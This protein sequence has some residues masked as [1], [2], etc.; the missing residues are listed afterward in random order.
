MNLPSSF[1]SVAIER[2][3]VAYKQLSPEERAKVVVLAAKG[4]FCSDLFENWSRQSGV[5]GE[6]L[7]RCVAGAGSLDGVRERLETTLLQEGNEALLIE[8][9]NRFLAENPGAFDGL[10]QHASNAKQSTAGAE[11]QSPGALP[12]DV[13]PP[14]TAAVPVEKNEVAV[15]RDK[16][17][18]L[19]QLDE[20]EALM[21]SVDSDIRRLRD[22]SGPIDLGALE[23]KLHRASRISL[24][25]H[26]Y[27][28]ELGNWQ[29]A[30]ALRE[31]IEAIPDAH[32]VWAG[33]LADFLGRVP[34]N[35]PLRRKRGELES[36]RD[37][38]ISDLRNFA[39]LGGVEEEVPGPSSVVRDWWD[40]AIGLS[41]D[42]FPGLEDWCGT[43]SLD[44]LADFLMEQWTLS[45]LAA[46]VAVRG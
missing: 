43:N 30:G 19:G 42:D 8:A 25:L 17:A 26:Q 28:A 9:V 37:A 2:L 18:A 46:I 16:G 44:H 24:G 21:E 5:D 14:Q 11:P 22:V 10:R 7:L 31:A 3:R 33:Q 36:L 4:R 20:L 1:D 6:E 29:S 27:G 35:H 45:R 15:P 12:S 40:W 38:A 39:D 32:A 13:V 34:V 41:D 23:R